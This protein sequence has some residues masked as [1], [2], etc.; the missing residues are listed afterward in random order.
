LDLQKQRFA[1]RWAAADLIGFEKSFELLK[2]QPAEGVHALR[3]VLESIVGRVCQVELNDAV[4]DH[5]PL[6]RKIALL[7]SGQNPIV[8]PD[9]SAKMTQVKTFGNLASH[10]P[11]LVDVDTFK[12]AFPI[13]LNV[14]CWFCE[15]KYQSVRGQQPAATN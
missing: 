12:A 4:E 7:S 10:M 2:V 15:S 3:Q 14:A 8:P 9:I 1:S 11:S 5:T 13:I 6:A